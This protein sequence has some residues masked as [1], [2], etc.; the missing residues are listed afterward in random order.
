MIE[1]SDLMFSY[2][3]G[4]P[5]LSGLSF[6]I[7]SGTHVALMGP[8][9]SGKTTLALLLKGLLS[10]SSGR[11]VV[12]GFSH[13]DE[14]SQF[15]I[16]KRVGLVFQ[17]PEDTIVATTVERELA[18]GLE[19]LGIPSDE[20]TARV[21]E[22]LSRFN[23]ERYRYTNP[24]NLS[25]GEMQRCA[26]AAVMVMRPEHLILDEPTSLLDPSGRS[27]LLAAVREITGNSTTVIHIT[28]FIEEAQPADRVIVLDGNGIDSDGPPGK[29]FSGA[30]RFRSCSLPGH[31]NLREKYDAGITEY[32][33]GKGRGSGHAL[34]AVSPIISLDSI[35]YRYDSGTP[36]EHRALDSI[37]LD[38]PEGSSTAL[39]GP[40]GSG[41]TT[42]LEIIAGITAPTGGTLNVDGHPVRA[43]AF[44]FPEDQMFAETVASYVDFGPHNIG[45]REPGLTAAVERTLAAVGLDPE[46]Y[47]DR[48]PLT[49]SGGEKRR[50]ALAGVLA[51]NPNV[52]VLDEPT[53]GLDISGL[54]FVTGFLRKYLDGG[55]TLV[56]STHD[57]EVVWEL[58]GYTVVLGEGRI[59]SAGH[60]LEVF[61]RSEWLK[62]LTE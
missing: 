40:S 57:F 43:M 44:Q 9:G 2:P 37:T 49:L 1:V 3:G 29:V 61:E 55:G 24:A 38:I 53:A 32:G 41:K 26:L 39:L 25:G 22:A 47:R 56:F 21:D 58:A 19:N 34:T 4:V 10:P 28:Q 15:E 6:S 20:M 48:D 50:A 51:M 12:G 27:S 17:N 14:R 42:L 5:V 59:E 45:V 62:S 52:L 18:F 13:D 36:F 23:L 33:A 46:I 31:G 11:I 60:T 16:M 35:T 30:R 8:N 7:D 54:E